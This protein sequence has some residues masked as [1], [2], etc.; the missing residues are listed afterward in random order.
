MQ[1]NPALVKISKLGFREQQ[2]KKYSKIP[3]QER[4]NGAC[5][6]ARVSQRW[7]V[8]RMRF[9]SIF[10][11]VMFPQPAKRVA[12]I[13]VNFLNLNQALAQREIPE[14]SN[15]RIVIKCVWKSFKNSQKSGLLMMARFD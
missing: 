4:E 6:F 1:S 15:L 14:G 10:M 13:D 11:F 9:T 2:L 3:Q 8:Q 12:V 7:E 5:S